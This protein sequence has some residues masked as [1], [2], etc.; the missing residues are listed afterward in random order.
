MHSMATDM[1]AV[2]V[3]LVIKL[4]LGIPVLYLI[5]CTECVARINMRLTNA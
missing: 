3:I 5:M 4:F 1:T 2:F